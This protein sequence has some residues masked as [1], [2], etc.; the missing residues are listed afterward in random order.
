[1]FFD[2]RSG[3]QTNT[4][5]SVVVL[6]ILVLAVLPLP[7]YS[8]NQS[9]TPRQPQ[10]VVEYFEDEFEVEITDSDGVPRE[11]ILGQDLYPGDLIRTFDSTVEIR[12]EPNGTIIKIAP[13]SSFTIEEIQGRDDAEKSSFRLTA[14][15]LRTVVRRAVGDEYE[16][17]T[18]FAV[19]GVRGTDFVLDVVP[20]ATDALFVQSGGV[21]FTQVSTG[22]SIFV[23]AGEGAD[24]LSDAFGA[25]PVAAAELR[26][27]F[28]GLEFQALDPADVSAP[29][30]ETTQDSTTDD[31]RTEAPEGE[32]AQEATGNAFMDNLLRHLRIQAGS[33]V[34]DRRTYGR[35]VIQPEIRRDTFALGFY[36]PVVYQENLFDATTW[37]QPGGNNE[38]SFGT[39]YDWDEE[40]K[41][42]TRDLATDIGLKFRYLAIGE[43]DDPFYVLAGNLRGMTLGHGMLVYDYANDWDFPAVRRIGL[44][45]G[46]DRERNGMELLVNDLLQPELYGARLYYRPFSAPLAFGMSATADVSAAEQLPDSTASASDQSL[47]AEARR[48]D[49]ILLNVG[50]DLEFP[51]MDTDRLRL[52][53]FSDIATPVPYLR[54]DV[55]LGDGAVRGLKTAILVDPETGELLNFGTMTGIFGRVGSVHF[56]GDYRSYRGLFRPFYVSGAYDRIRGRLAANTVGYF[57][58]TKNEDYDNYGMGFYGEAAIE[59]FRDRLWLRGGY[60]WPW[61]VK[62]TGG[63]TPADDD[64]LLAEVRIREDL[65]PIPLTASLRYERRGFVPTL[66]NRGRFEDAGLFDAS[67]TLRGD[68]AYRLSPG[69]SV[70]VTA[71]TTLVYT[72]DGEIQYDDGR[73]QTATTIAVETRIGY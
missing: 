39:D 2:S 29:R 9:G 69:L 63:W 67:T 36:L 38:W 50:L 27:L 55:Q 61:D 35:V 28:D 48:V 46:L 41:N 14:G 66:L 31:G 43:Q 25:Q 8:Q 42:A 22:R 11:V 19:G 16:F 13:E 37:Y 60:L 1:M 20:G 6:A 18:P 59:L 54:E 17:R 4:P 73:P 58:D 64:Q 65:L 40:P 56:R 47:Y 15:R 32:P 23:E 71:S 10:A 30:P 49:P 3:P 7:L 26:S 70:A 53:A 57:A 44:L 62:E 21:R 12:L 5:V 52:V 68:V 24:A 33:V 45:V 34:I 51:V 72:D